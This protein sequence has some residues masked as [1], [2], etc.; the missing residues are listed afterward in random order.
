M[1]IY[2]L[3]EITKREIDSNLLLAVK[4]ASRGHNIIISNMNNFKSLIEKNLLKP[5]I[6][7][8]K[9]L[10]HDQKK[11]SFHE[12]IKKSKLVLTSLDEEN[13]LVRDDLKPFVE[14]RF[15]KKDLDI[16][17]KVFCWGKHDYISLKKKYPLHQK[18]FVMTGS[19]RLDMWKSNFSQYWNT[20]NQIK[21]KNILVTLNF[22]LIN[23]FETVEKI[24]MKYQKSGYFDRNKNYKDELNQYVKESHKILTEY[25][26]LINNLIS[27]FKGCNFIIRPHPREKISFWKKKINSKKNVLIS[28]SGNFN[29]E[30]A[31]ARLI[32]H[33]SSTTAFQAAI[34][35]VPIISFV[36]LISKIS[37]GKI[38]NKLGVICKNHREVKSNI[39]KILKKKLKINDKKVQKIINYKLYNSGDLSTSKIIN[40]WEELCKNMNT[41]EINYTKIKTQL[42]F[43]NKIS[44]TKKFFY[45]LFSSKQEKNKENKFED[46][47]KINIENKVN[48]I[49]KIINIKCELDI[50]ITQKKFLIIKKIN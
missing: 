16:C 37:Y 38:S 50:N 33:N 30:L 11:R 15:S 25:I 45:N 46:L 18:K 4:A 27:D 26:K 9:S 41:E 24:F 36:P 34:N 12:L 42:F 19:P 7:H 13:G 14:M 31:S 2:I 29:E 6:F 5:G 8:T 10:V 48:L 40:C 1:N 23:G 47:N 20:K 32:I 3:T 43:V 28:N 22:A 35:N 39:S 49:K 44:N 17:D 21:K